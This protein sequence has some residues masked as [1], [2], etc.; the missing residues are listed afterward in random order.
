[1]GKEEPDMCNILHFIRKGL[2]PQ[3]LKEAPI[4]TNIVSLESLQNGLGYLKYS[5]KRRLVIISGP[6]N[7][8]F[9]RN[10]VIG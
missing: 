9:I 5:P 6:Y 3:L 8:S 1:M 10:T 2:V 7:D 4:I